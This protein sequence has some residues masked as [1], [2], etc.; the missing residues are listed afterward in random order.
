MSVV[1]EIKEAFRQ[2][3]ETDNLTPG[4]QA[5]W[6]ELDS[7]AKGV[8]TSTVSEAVESPHWIIHYFMTMAL[9][10]NDIK[11]MMLWDAM[12]ETLKRELALLN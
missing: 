1:E 2:S 5:Y 8:A 10:I 6:E 9:Q 12:H 11:N 4:A 7:C 3:Q